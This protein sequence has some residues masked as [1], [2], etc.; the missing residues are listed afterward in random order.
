MKR[1]VYDTNYPDQL[2]QITQQLGNGT[3]VTDYDDDSYG[4]ITQR[5]LP[6]NEKGQRMW[7]RYTYEPVMNIYVMF[8]EDAFGCSS[9][10]NNFDYRYGIALER[11]DLN[12][13]YY[14]TDIDSMGRI[15][16]VHGPTR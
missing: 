12:N 14:E 9:E 2:T 1:P 16:G 6:S 10:A 3:V 4:N 11:R 13:F 7:Y 5:T 15:T 8:V